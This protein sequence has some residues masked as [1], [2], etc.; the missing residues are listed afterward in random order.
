M[1][2]FYCGG[3]MELLKLYIFFFKIGL[4]TFGSGYSMLPRL[5]KIF[6]YKYH[7]IT[8]EEMLDYL[9][10]GQCTPGVIS[11]NIATFIG[12]KKKGIAG[13]I[14]A[15]L[16]MITPSFLILLVISFFLEMIVDFEIVKHALAGIRLATVAL[17][18]S[19]FTNL[20]KQLIVDWKTF[21][22]FL[23]VVAIGLLLPIRSIYLVIYGGILGYFLSR[24]G[25]A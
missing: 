10:I 11:I 3:C 20:Y 22:L 23:S 25:K 1:I 5:Q 16:G 15:T 4:Q 7:V 19:T 21:L 9:T 2:Q 24:E 12:Y 8:E 18:F 14:F 17:I 13:G 6:V